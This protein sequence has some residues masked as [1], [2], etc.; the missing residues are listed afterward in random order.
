MQPKLQFHP[1]T[2]LIQSWTLVW[3]K[4]SLSW[5]PMSN[6]DDF[7]LTGHG[8]RK[9]KYAIQ[10]SSNSRLSKNWFLLRE[11]KKSWVPSS[12]RMRP[13]VLLIATVFLRHGRIFQIQRAVW[14]KHLNIKYCSSSKLRIGKL[15]DFL[16]GAMLQLHSFCRALLNAFFFS[17]RPATKLGNQDW[18]VSGSNIPNLYRSVDKIL[19]EGYVQWWC[20][21]GYKRVLQILK[22]WIIFRQGFWR[23]YSR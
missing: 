22:Y 21:W 23:F 9:K 2:L 15:P 7:L 12:V 8:W 19:I 13:T 20:S 10:S 1:S 5:H 3:L 17:S 11:D 4:G 14:T 16:M 18:W 6:Q